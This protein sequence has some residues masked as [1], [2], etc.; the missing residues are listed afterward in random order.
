MTPGFDLA[1]VLS[2]EF[3]D[4]YV[5]GFI[6]T[7]ELAVAAWILAFLLAFATEKLHELRVLAAA[8]GQDPSAADGAGN[9]ALKAELQAATIGDDF[10]RVVELGNELCAIK[11]QLDILSQK[12]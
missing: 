11:K 9:D 12:K 10:S 8:L 4:R 1:T 6:T 5:T 2:G 3:L 7:M